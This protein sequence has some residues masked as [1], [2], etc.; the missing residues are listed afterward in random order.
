[1]DRRGWIETALA[2]VFSI[3]M[4][5]S[6][7][8]LLLFMLPLQVLA[9][10][11]GKKAFIFSAAGVFLGSQFLKLALMPDMAGTGSVMVADS[12]MFLF[13]ILGL[14][15][16]NYMFE[17]FRTVLKFLIV[18]AVAGLC[19]VPVLYYLN[20]DQSFYTI[21]TDQLDSVLVM[22]NGASA[23]SPGL[24]GSNIFSSV[25]ADDMYTVFKIYFL[26]SFLAVYFYL[27]VLTWWMG[28]RIGQRSIGKNISLPKVKEFI[29]PEKLVWLFFI[30]LTIVLLGFL[31]SG[32]GVKLETGLVGI[33]VSNILYIM[34]TLY[35][36]Q[37]YGLV[38]FVMEKKNIAPALRRFTG[39]LLFVSFFILP[40]AVVFAILL[41]GLGVSELWINYRHNEKELIQ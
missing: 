17:G 36:L 24:N 25:S 3:I 37:G 12:A 15:A 2:A 29:V 11:R 38:Q 21:M 10:K 26:N 19:S 31:L 6:G 8:L 13:L 9:I 39:I 4:S 22:F 30:P 33:A 28:S 7:P 27:L 32:K 40:L 5:V 1:M 16:V 35:G 20:A 14:Y 23:G 34:G 18:A 41:P